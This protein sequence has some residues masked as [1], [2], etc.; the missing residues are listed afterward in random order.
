[1][2][3][4]TLVLLRN[5]FGKVTTQLIIILIALLFTRFPNNFYSLTFGLNLIS[6]KW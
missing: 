6:K 2:I 5:F 3:A 4:L 1:M